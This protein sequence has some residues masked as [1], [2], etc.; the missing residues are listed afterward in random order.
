MS[1]QKELKY[2]DEV[3]V[4]GK[5]ILEVYEC[6]CGYNFGVDAVHIERAGAVDFACPNCEI[7]HHIMW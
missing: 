2:M 7:G 5:A 1:E 4:K 3:V 6:K